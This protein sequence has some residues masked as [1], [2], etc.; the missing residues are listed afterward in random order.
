[1]SKVYVPEGYVFV[2][3]K[4][5]KQ[6]KHPQVG[7]M[8][9]SKSNN[10]LGYPCGWIPTSVDDTNYKFFDCMNYCIPKES[11]PHEL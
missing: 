8:Y 10:S 2:N 9:N 11:L 4:M 5:R 7:M 1:M 6:F 3:A